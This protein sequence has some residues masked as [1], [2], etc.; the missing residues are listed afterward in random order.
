MATR[1]LGALI[2]LVVVAA[3]CSGDDT[4]E[5]GTTTAPALE[6]TAATVDPPDASSTSTVSPEAG[7]VD[8]DVAAWCAVAVEAEESYGDGFV[9]LAADPEAVRAY[10]E[11]IAELTDRASEVV[12]ADIADDWAISVRRSELVRQA[13]VDTDYD[14]FVADFSAV[15]DVEDAAD[16]AETAID[17]FNLERCG[18]ELPDDDD[19]GDGFD[20]A[21]GTLR[22]QFVA[23]LVDGGFTEGEAVCIFDEYDFSAIDTDAENDAV[24]AAL[25]ACDLPPE[26]LVELGLATE[27]DE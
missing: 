17:A 7:A 19:D 5:P 1:A 8:D 18:L 11:G 10:L 20:P 26:R 9:R 24:L 27:V 23:S 21:A 16:A 13:I 15:A 22:D 14:V 3:A 25:I 6:A 4:A 12:P 2:T